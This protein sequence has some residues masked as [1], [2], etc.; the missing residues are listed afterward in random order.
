MW[1]H[2]IG[3]LKHAIAGHSLLSDVDRIAVAEIDMVF[4]TVTLGVCAAAA[5]ALT[6]TAILYHLGFDTS[7]K[8]EWWC[9]YIVACAISHLVLKHRYARSR[10]QDD[11]LSH[12]AFWFTVISFAEG[13]GWGWAV[14]SLAAGGPVAVQ[15]MVVL[16]IAGI[17][18]A[19][20]PAFGPY[21]PAFAAF[22][23]P[24]TLP[25]LVFGLWS[26]DPYQHAGA[27]FMLLFIVGMGA[28]AIVFNRTF[29]QLI[30]MRMAAEQMAIDLK[31]QKDI[32]EQA[33]LAK[34]RFLAAA[35]HDLRQPVHAIG[36][37]VGALRGVAMPPEGQRLLEQ[38][39]S[40][41]N[42]MDGLFTALLD[43]SRLDAGA[44][45]VVR[46][47]FALG[48]LL[49]RICRDHAAE[50]LAKGVTLIHKPTTA[51][52]NSDPVLVEQ[53]ARNLISNAVRY[54]D[55]GRIV[56]AT[57]RRGAT[58]RLQVWDTGRGIASEQHE[59]VFEEYFQLGNPERDRTKGLGLGLAIVRRV[60]TLLDADLTLRSQPG[61]GSCF[62]LTLPF[63]DAPDPHEQVEH[64]SSAGALA[65]GLVVVIDD[66]RAIRE[67]MTSLLE[68]WGH[69]VM[70]A[71]SGD[72]AIQVLS[73]CRQRPDLIICDYRLRD[74][75][76]GVAV[77][78]RLRAD[79]NED[80]PAMLITGDTGP[81]RLAEAHASGLLLLHKPVSNSKLRAAIVN[82]MATTQVGTSAPLS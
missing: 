82:L 77:V 69:Q 30:S 5:T 47:P 36:L 4:G 19:A 15:Y 44:V 7:H 18:S 45:D 35:S 39:E 9:V 53:I 54:T 55:V 6:L 75:E 71:S 50:A 61:R 67:A 33:N 65:R 32:A 73:G 72:E 38:I 26:A 21:L 78:D 13:I 10:R 57:R 81:D 11:A 22:F 49:D 14:V 8:G 27:W 43:I 42:A 20:V 58:L 23:L 64:R 37:F 48:P 29:R 46:R 41:T 68:S 62:E 52:V 17:C 80:V 34:S 76:N 56:I 70:V 3:K 79:Y 74:G 66:E 2:R 24:A 59:R 60:A 40:S 1:R 12:F 31:R 51:I 25:Y 16:V 28:L 63:A